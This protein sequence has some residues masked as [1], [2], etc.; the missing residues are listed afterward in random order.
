MERD[1]CREGC[2]LEEVGR[3]REMH[4]E[5]IWSGMHAGRVACS[6]KSDGVGKAEKKK[7]MQRC[8]VAHE[9]TR[10]MSTQQQRR[11]HMSAA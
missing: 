9:E 8:L 2:L 7:E 4:G 6:R 5:Y 10:D 1:A 11:L 3:R